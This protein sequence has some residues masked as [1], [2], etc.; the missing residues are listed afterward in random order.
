M[1][2]IYSKELKNEIIDN[3]KDYKEAIERAYANAEERQGLQESN[4]EEETE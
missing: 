1:R 4:G 3:Y 2:K